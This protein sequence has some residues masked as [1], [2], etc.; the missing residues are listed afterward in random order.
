[1]RL[2]ATGRYLLF[3]SKEV[4][5]EIFGNFDCDGI[6]Q[7]EIKLGNEVPL[8]IREPI[9]NYT[10]QEI[11]I[12]TN[13]GH[14]HDIIQ[15][16]KWGILVVVKYSGNNLEVKIVLPPMKFKFITGIFGNV[17]GI[18][19]N[20]LTSRLGYG[21][22]ESDREQFSVDEWLKFWSSFST[23]GVNSTDYVCD[24]A[25]LPVLWG[26]DDSQEEITQYEIDCTQQ[27]FLSANFYDNDYLKQA[28]ISK[29]YN[30]TNPVVKCDLNDERF[31][32]ERDRES[33]Q[34]MFSVPNN[35]GDFLLAPRELPEQNI[36]RFQPIEDDIDKLQQVLKDIQCSS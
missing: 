25:D 13:E 17:D 2:V 30:D 23:G 34:V 10:S 22:L 33:L 24:T 21:A 29:V 31:V 19:E 36:T 7:L 1:M 28:E 15:I 6:N 9:Q 20:D 11:S 3:H 8:N 27:I 4:D 5:L 26:S 12:L 16:L 32:F 14:S 35:R 18:R